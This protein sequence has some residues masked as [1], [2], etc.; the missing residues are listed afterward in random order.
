MDLPCTR[1]LASFWGANAIT[2][3]KWAWLPGMLT[4][5]GAWRVLDVCDS[6]V[7]LT[8]ELTERDLGYG[9]YCTEYQP[10]KPN[11]F[12]DFRDAATRGC[13]LELVRIA[14]QDPKMFA[15]FTGDNWVVYS[16]RRKISVGSTEVDALLAAL[17][18]AP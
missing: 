2:Y 8:S 10:L 6:E 16:G 9:E 13:L 7:M 3:T 15:Q 1:E 4:L 5:G 11:T 18:V 17:E 12:P 14:W